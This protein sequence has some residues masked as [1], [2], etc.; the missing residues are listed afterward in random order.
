M[1]TEARP[2]ET[3]ADFK[4]RV[5]INGFPAALVQKFTHGSA[6]IGERKRAGA[7][8]NH[9]VYEPGMLSY[10]P[11]KLEMVLPLEGPGRDLLNNWFKRG[12]DP[13]TG[14]GERTGS[15]KQDFTVYHLMNTA[16]VNEAVEYF[17]AYI[18]E[19]D[20]GELDAMSEDGNL[21][22]KFSLR[23]DWRRKVVK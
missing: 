1:A 9:V 7:G 15:L 4:F 10:E 13:A 6:K 21:I 16:D 20:L 17:G 8:Q 18:N 2:I 23:F 19:E 14:N 5:E 12:Q 22:P 3:Q 11:C